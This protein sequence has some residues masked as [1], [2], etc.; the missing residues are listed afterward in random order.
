MNMLWH[1]TEL[2]YR[3]SLIAS[4]AQGMAAS[5]PWGENVT[6]DH[7]PDAQRYRAAFAQSAIMMADAIIAELNAEQQGPIS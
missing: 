2:D 1:T 7:T 6:R 3:L 4:I 5:H